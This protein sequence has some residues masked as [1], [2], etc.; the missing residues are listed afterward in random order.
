MDLF[1]QTFIMTLLVSNSICLIGYIPMPETDI[2]I[3]S[4]CIEIFIHILGVRPETVA[5]FTLYDFVNLEDS[6]DWVILDLHKRLLELYAKQIRPQ[7]VLRENT[8]NRRT[9][10]KKFVITTS[11]FFIDDSGRARL[12]ISD[13]LRINPML[14]CIR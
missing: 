12:K 2:L 3:C 5:N 14:Q 8:V 1:S 9:P 11:R 4:L 10:C 7:W 13:V 6:T